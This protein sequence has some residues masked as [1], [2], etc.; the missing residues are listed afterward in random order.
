MSEPVF[1]VPTRPALR[2]HGGKWRLAPHVLRLFP[3]HRTYVE[4]FGGAAS[5]LIRKP[6]SYAEIYNDLDGEIVAL[7]RVLRDRRKAR[8]LARLC[9]ATPYSREEFEASYE[10]SADPVEQARRTLVRSWMA[11][12]SSGLR[13]NKAGFRIGLRDVGQSSPDDWRGFPSAIVAICERLQGVIIECRP[14]AKILATHDAR[15]TLFYVDPPYPHGTRSTKRPANGLN[16]GYRHEMSDAHHAVLLEQ[17]RGLSGMVVVSSYPSNAY[18]AALAGW[19][20]VE[21]AARAADRTE[22]TEILFAN[23]AAAAALEAEALPLLAGA[24]AAA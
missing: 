14:A 24:R 1:L 23:P 5:V 6:R 10:P 8:E 2:Y 21:V 11:H 15:D 22:R 4:P 19:M 7:F 3:R 18:D 16:H 9:R 13:G 17:L 20:R 12:G